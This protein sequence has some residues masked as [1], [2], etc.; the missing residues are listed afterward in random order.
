MLI[1]LD[2]EAFCQLCKQEYSFWVTTTKRFQISIQNMQ[3]FRWEMNKICDQ[4]HYEKKLVV[5]I[6]NVALVAAHFTISELLSTNKSRDQVL[7][8]A[9]VFY[10]L[11]DF[12]IDLS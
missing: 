10:V 11:N 8:S 6:V 5:Y 1:L 3:I 12:L 2:L 9:N 4:I 7:A